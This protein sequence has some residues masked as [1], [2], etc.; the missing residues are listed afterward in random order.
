MT[1]RPPVTYRR[2][3]WTTC[4]LDDRSTHEY[5][6]RS[7]SRR[8]GQTEGVCSGTTVHRKFTVRSK[9]VGIS[10][11]L[12]SEDTYDAELRMYKDARVVNSHRKAR[13]F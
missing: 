8:Y 2:E 3:Q 4:H 1:V 11:Q 7:C 10:I 12:I 13:R 9:Q 6:F 5:E